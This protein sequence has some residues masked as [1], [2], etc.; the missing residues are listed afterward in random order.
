MGFTFLLLLRLLKSK[1]FQAYKIINKYKEIIIIF[2]PQYLKNK[3]TLETVIT[4]NIL[5]LFSVLRIS[6]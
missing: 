6:T 1:T 2:N 3:Q 4:Y 5:L